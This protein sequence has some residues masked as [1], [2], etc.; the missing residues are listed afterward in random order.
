MQSREVGGS[1]PKNVECL[2][3]IQTFRRWLEANGPE[4]TRIFLTIAS[5]CDW[6][7]SFS[8]SEREEYL[9]VR[10]TEAILDDVRR[11]QGARIL[12]LLFGKELADRDAAT[13]LGVYQ[14]W[15]DKSTFAVPRLCDDYERRFVATLLAGLTQVTADDIW[16]A[17]TYRGAGQLLR[18]ASNY[19]LTLADA[20]RRARPE[21]PRSVHNLAAL[22]LTD[23]SPLFP[24]R[25][26]CDYL[27][28]NK[29]LASFLTE[30]TV[31]SFWS[32]L[33]VEELLGSTGGSFPGEG[34]IP[35]GVEI[36][37][38]LTG[39]FVTLDALVR[40]EHK[41]LILDLA[42]AVDG[43]YG[44][45]GGT[46][47]DEWILNCLARAGILAEDVERVSYYPELDV[48]YAR[49][50]MATPSQAKEGFVAFLAGRFGSIFRLAGTVTRF[51]G[52]MTEFDAE[53]NPGLASWKSS[54]RLPFTEA[55]LHLL[56]LMAAT[57][58]V[59]WKLTFNSEWWLGIRGFE[60]E[61]PVLQPILGVTSEARAL[62]ID[63]LFL[64]TPIAYPVP[65][66]LYFLRS[67]EEMM[68]TLAALSQEAARVLNGVDFRGYLES[69]GYPNM[70]LDSEAFVGLNGLSKALD[71]HSLR[72]VV[73]GHRTSYPFYYPNLLLESKD[74][75][76]GPEEM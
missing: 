65:Y 39:L 29:E 34:R 36:A 10:E 30:G 50:P 56:P 43:L 4:I 21:Q 73:W 26:I 44:T 12:A 33:R 52:V 32:L 53:H 5:S 35:T 8:L 42:S 7:G 23:P 76:F 9:V 58:D 46:Q 22:L 60:P 68:K 37:F 16:G 66:L 49:D 13:R 69:M 1:V 25:V 24:S 64:R 61:S 74:D 15:V 41:Q 3:E 70:E 20:T 59:Q 75:S 17:G 51:F 48:N 6:L 2:F 55:T 28:E 38:L 47:A 19:L 14:D 72:H 27:G 71:I 54:G 63:V 62:I 40:G 57:A 31:E 45:E 18:D 67:Q 11:K